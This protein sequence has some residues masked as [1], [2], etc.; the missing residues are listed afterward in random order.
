MVTG[1]F[2]SGKQNNPAK[3]KPQEAV[4]VEVK[5]SPVIDIVP[6]TKPEVKESNTIKL[7]MENLKELGVSSQNAD[8]FVLHSNNTI[9]K[10]KINT[11]LRL[12]HFMAQVLHESGN[13]RYVKELSNGKQYEGRKDLGNINVGDGP[14]FLGRGFIQTTGRTN[15]KKYGDSIG[16]DLL[17]NPE[18]LETPELASDSAGWFW[19]TTKTK[20]G[21]SLND[22]ADQD[23]FLTITLKVNGGFHGIKDRL[24]KLKKSYN[25]FGITDGDERIDKILK[26]CEDNLTK[27]DR[28]VT[29]KFLMKYVPNL[30]V[31]NDL[32]KI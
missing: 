2:V 3:S 18:K 9:E 10:Y 13:F 23:N 12:S 28:S 1:L 27:T 25:L 19:I 22:L 4:P 16:T 20:A 17:T 31:V 26:I 32:K 11:P 7:T 21:S 29:E 24:Q 5:P 14:L 6:E 30:S 8:K 15:Y